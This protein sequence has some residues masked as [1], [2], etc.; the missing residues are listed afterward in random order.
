[1]GRTFGEGDEKVTVDF[2]Q[3]GP[4][5]LVTILALGKNLRSSGRPS[6][7]IAQFGPG[8]VAHEDHTPRIMPQVDGQTLLDTAA[9]LM[10][11][12]KD[13]AAEKAKKRGWHPA[14]E[15][16]DPNPYDRAAEGTFTQLRLAGPIAREVVLETGRLDLAMDQMRA[17]LDALMNSWGIDPA[18]YHSLKRRTV[19]RSNAG[20]W[21][22]TND[23][24][25]KMLV[26]GMSSV[27]HFRLM[28]DEA[29]KPTD[30]AVQ[31]AGGSEF[32][33]RTCEL[34]MQRARF[35]PA[36]D[37]EGRPVASFYVNSVRWMTP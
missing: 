24:P 25:E 14:P 31:T 36:L 3:Y 26:R 33:R 32:D 35:D 27:V 5:R 16:L 21:A 30:C 13:G 19:P 22:T 10:P 8:G 9:L 34:M 20:A 11:K 1:M 18:T 7:L 12:P 37:R 23:Y 17:C 15:D 4:G 6:T 28:V 29:G 2:R